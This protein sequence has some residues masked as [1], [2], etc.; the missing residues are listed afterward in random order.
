DD[1]DKD[2][3]VSLVDETQRRLDDAETFD[4]D[5]LHGDEVIM[6]M[7]DEREVSISVED[8]VAPTIPVTTAGEGVT[9]TKIDEI[10]TTSAP[11]IVI[12]EITL[13]QT[14]IEIKVAKP[15][16]VN[17]A[18]TTTTTTRPKAGGVV[19]QEPS[20]FR[21]TASSPQASKPQRTKTKGKQYD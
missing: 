1:T 14:L 16:A 4:T 12:D 21:T 17:T 6:D 19:V 20:E 13:D 7:V 8:S 5:D 2:A 18:A 11:T 9:A 10:T 15:K 3:E